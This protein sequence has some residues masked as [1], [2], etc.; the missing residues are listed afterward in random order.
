MPKQMQPNRETKIP[1]WAQRLQ[2]ARKLT[3][4][5]PTAFAKRI[6]LSQQR[7]SNYERGDREPN[8]TAW[9]RIISHLPVGLDF[10]ILGRSTHQNGSGTKR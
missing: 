10:I 3:G 4:L 1:D 9:E 7:Y 6:G 8:V 5:G 2:D